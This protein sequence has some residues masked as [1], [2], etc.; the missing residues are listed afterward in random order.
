MKNILIGIPLLLLSMNVLSEGV[1]EN[2]KKNSVQS[3]I[4]MISGWYCDANKIEIVF[5]DRLPKEAA[6]GTTRRDTVG[7]CGDDDNGFGL[8]WGWS[9]LG[10]GWHTVRAYA[11]GKLFA[12]NDFYVGQIGDGSYLRG[13]EGTFELN[14]FPDKETEV[15][16]EWNESTQNFSILESRNNTPSVNKTPGVDS[17]WSGLWTSISF[18]GNGYLSINDGIRQGKR[19]LVVFGIYTNTGEFEVF[20]GA[21][22]GNK[23]RVTATYPNE[24][25]V[26]DITLL[27]PN[28]VKVYMVSCAP[29]SECGFQTGT[30]FFMDKLL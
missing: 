12:E 8:Q 7:A 2:P 29:A 14:G 1:L 20:E 26:F 5:D 18:N 17:N 10:K 21:I 15:V 28:R 30:I 13:A 24:D 16:V 19:W 22:S 27:S 3:G 11:D 25:V 23:A 4:G 9:I 6:Y